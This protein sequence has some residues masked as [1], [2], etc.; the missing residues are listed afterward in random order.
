MPSSMR[1]FNSVIGSHSTLKADSLAVWEGPPREPH[2][3]EDEVGNAESADGRNEF[4]ARHPIGAK[5]VD[6]P[7]VRLLAMATDE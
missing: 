2:G 6:S 4:K 3:P 7:I 5:A 1:R